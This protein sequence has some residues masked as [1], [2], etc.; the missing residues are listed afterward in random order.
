MAPAA[1]QAVLDGKRLLL[2]D[3]PGF[4]DTRSTLDRSDAVILEEIAN[5]IALQSELGVKM[6]SISP[7]LLSSPGGSFG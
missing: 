4:N 3:T 6:A 5:L 7:H 2:I 1:I